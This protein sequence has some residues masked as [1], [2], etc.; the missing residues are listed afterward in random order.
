MA[1]KAQIKRR[2]HE[3]R[4]KADRQKAA[5]K[6]RRT[7]ELRTG[8]NSALKRKNSAEWCREYGAK[9]KENINPLGDVSAE[10]IGGLAPQRS[11]MDSQWKRPLDDPEMAR[12]EAEAQKLI[13]ERNKRVAPAFSKGA[14]QLIT[15][16]NDFRTAGRKV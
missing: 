16:V 4:M 6:E 5:E 14:Y 13:A 11:V 3:Q 9:L 2:L 1:S 7:F 10:S 8:V 12:R 15:D